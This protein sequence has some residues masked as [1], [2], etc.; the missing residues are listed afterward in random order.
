MIIFQYLKNYNN[1][2]IL[3]YVILLY[4]I[5]YFSNY[6]MTYTFFQIDSFLLNE[7]DYEIIIFKIF[8]V[9]VISIKDKR[10]YK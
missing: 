7:K 9:F 4:I 8:Y 1:Y 2:F 10:K 5:I 6:Q 3:S